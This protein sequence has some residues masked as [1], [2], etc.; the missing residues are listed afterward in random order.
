MKDIEIELFDR[1]VKKAEEVF[2]NSKTTYLNKN[3]C[4]IYFD[5]LWNNRYENPGSSLFE[6]NF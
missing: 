2:L 5:L 1:I 6:T 4:R 3:F